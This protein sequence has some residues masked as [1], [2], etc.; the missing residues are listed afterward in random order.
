MKEI[1]ASIGERVNAH[2]IVVNVMI[3]VITESLAKY[4][5]NAIFSS[6]NWNNFHE[7]GTKTTFIHIIHSHLFINIYP[8]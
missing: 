4:Q 7:K 6:H 2:N 8:K 5:S 3:M 1:I